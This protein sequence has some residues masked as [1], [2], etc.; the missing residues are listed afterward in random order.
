MKLEAS[1][2][3][4]Y[5]GRPAL[6]LE[7][8][9]IVDVELDVGDL[10]ARLLPPTVVPGASPLVRILALDVGESD[11]STEPFF[12]L[13]L[14]ARCEHG[15][16]EAWYAL[17]HLVGPEGD[18]VFG[19]E[20]FGYPSRMASIEWSR[21]GASFALAAS[22]LG[23]RV[24]RLA[25]AASRAAPRGDSIAAIEVLGLRLHPPYRLMTEHGF[26]E[27][28]PRV[29]LVGQPWSFELAAAPVDV[30]RLELELPAEPGPARI[31]KPDPW[32]ELAGG[33]VVRASSGRGRLRRGPGS[34]I[35]ELEGWA[36]F[37]AERLD[38]TMDAGKATSGDVTHTFLVR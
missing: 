3:D 32:Y 11:W 6:E 16:R 35:A 25:L 38:G 17:S 4:R 21:E 37:Y 24:A 33:K 7:L 29:D 22:R 27:P 18:V 28:G 34:T 8:R 2:L 31:G 14:L 19:R 5:K 13:W 12:E 30:A 36:P 15:G 20:T 10:H 1:E 26:V 9:A 23:R